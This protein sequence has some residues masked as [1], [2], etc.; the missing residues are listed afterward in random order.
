MGRRKGD[1]GDGGSL[2]RTRRLPF[3]CSNPNITIVPLLPGRSTSINLTQTEFARR[4]ETAYSAFDF[5]AIQDNLSIATLASHHTIDFQP[6]VLAR[7]LQAKT[8]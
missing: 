3:F 1:G 2:R 7:F 4:H 8:S 6:G 5:S